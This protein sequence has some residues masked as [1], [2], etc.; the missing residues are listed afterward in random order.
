[1]QRYKKKFEEEIK[2][3]LL[4]EMA[5]VGDVG[6]LSVDVYTDHEPLHFHVLKKDA[7]EVKIELNTLNILGYKW[8]KNGKEIS[9]S[10]LKNLKNWLK[11]K[12]IKNKKFTNFEAI[13]FLWDSMN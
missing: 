9:E 8:Q 2:N 1:M 7:F 6:Q 5:H 12:S 3:K 4:K 11:M 13:K 10:E